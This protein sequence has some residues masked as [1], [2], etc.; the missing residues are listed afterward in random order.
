MGI[1]VASVSYE[2]LAAYIIVKLSAYSIQ[3]SICKILKDCGKF[4]MT[5][6]LFT[7]RSE[8]QRY[9]HGMNHSLCMEQWGRC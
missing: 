5:L 7:G 3:D 1:Q 2:L 8:R 4:H 6:P 9:T